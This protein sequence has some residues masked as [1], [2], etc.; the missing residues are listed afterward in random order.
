MRHREPRHTTIQVSKKRK[1]E[2]QATSNDTTRSKK[3]LEKRGALLCSNSPWVHCR[4]GGDACEALLGADGKKVSR[5][6]RH[7]YFRASVSKES[8]H[9]LNEHLNEIHEEWSQLACAHP[10]FEITPKPILLH[11]NSFGGSVFAGFWA[12]DLIRQSKIPVHTIVEG[13]TASCGTLMSVVGQKRYMRPTASMLIHQLSSCSAGKMEDIRD[14][15]QNLEQMSQTIET[16][17]HQHT[18]IKK[19]TLKRLLTRDLWWTPQ[20]CIDL[21]LVDAIWTGDESS[22]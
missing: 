7:I 4:W 11:I 19:K 2:G 3:K 18:S 6:G 9:A 17:Y 1:R 16:I 14:D 12:V 21:G 13:A 20:K 8:V 22:E 5:E 15:F 10:E